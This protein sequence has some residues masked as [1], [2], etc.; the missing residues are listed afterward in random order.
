MNILITG[1]T[2]FIGSNLYKELIKNGHIIY[3][4]VRKQEDFVN[5]QKNNIVC[6][7]YKDI[8]D[9]ENFFSENKLDGVIHLASKFLVNHNTNDI[10]DLINSNILFSTQLLELSCKNNLKWFI[11]TGTFWQH[12]NDFDYMPVNLYSATK[13]AF[14][15]IAKFY[16]ETFNIRFTTLKLN[17]TY[18]ASDTRSKVFNLWLKLSK[19]NE[20]LDMSLG[21]QLM[22][23]VYIDDV[24]QAY[25]ELV[26]WIND[27]NNI[28][29]TSYYISSGHFISLKDL[30]SIFEETI[31]KKLNINWGAREYR[32]REIMKP[33]CKGLIVP[34][35]KPKI[36]FKEGINKIVNT[37]L[38]DK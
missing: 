12:Y 13:Q 21:E 25:I 18:G 29:E 19:S 10:N 7:L 23:I 33:A 26:N 6:C 3:S 35:W 38:K 1:I 24:V 37:T 32:Q 20:T 9:L 36:T 4:I 11:N 14:E 28:I 22:D 8:S 31:G 27:S 34:N 2:G 15:A 16:T 5:L 17:D 30:A